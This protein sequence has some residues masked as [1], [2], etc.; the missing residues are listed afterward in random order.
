MYC[1][2]ELSVHYKQVTDALKEACEQSTSTLYSSWMM[3]DAELEQWL[4]EEVEKWQAGVIEK[5]LHP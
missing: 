1:Y 2:L 5:V 3:V 4:M